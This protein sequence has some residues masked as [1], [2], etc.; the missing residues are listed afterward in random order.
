MKLI[1]ISLAIFLL[2][3]FSS[4]E[5]YHAKDTV[6]GT[7]TNADSVLPAHGHGQP[8]EAAK[9]EAPAKVFRR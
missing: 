2:I 7:P 8:H 1:K 4:C 9:S 6:D 3:G 5:S